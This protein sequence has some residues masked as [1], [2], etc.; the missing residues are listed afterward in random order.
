MCRPLLHPSYLKLFPY[1][2]V[3]E[4]LTTP[5]LLAIPSGHYLLQDMLQE[6]GALDERERL[7]RVA[8]ILELNIWGFFV[9]K[10]LTLDF[11]L[12]D[13]DCSMKWDFSLIEQRQL[14]R[15]LIQ[16]ILQYTLIQ[17]FKFSLP[18]MIQQNLYLIF[19]WFNNVSPW[20][21]WGTCPLKVNFGKSLFLV[22]K[23][24]PQAEKPSGESPGKFSVF[25]SKVKSKSLPPDPFRTCVWN[26]RCLVHGLIGFKRS[27]DQ[28]VTIC[29]T[30]GLNLCIFSFE[31]WPIIKLPE[32]LRCF[33]FNFCIIL[34]FFPPIQSRQ[35]S[36]CPEYQA[37]NGGMCPQW[38]QRGDLVASQHVFSRR[39]LFC[40][41][42]YGEGWTKHQIISE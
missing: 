30:I 3:L 39:I 42:S 24:F 10:N 33:V 8:G 32:I 22:D 13:R 11:H 7:V 17:R 21:G 4:A 27:Y 19:G 28:M 35:E 9:D 5:F 37:A 20:N 2:T 26:H 12:N 31:L 40:W 38:L 1:N 29:I 25:W 36:Y 34:F 41:L 16:K 14:L 15:E 18:K 6:Q 23:N